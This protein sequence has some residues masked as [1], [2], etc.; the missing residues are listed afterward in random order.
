MSV[1]EQIN[2]ATLTIDVNVRAEANLDKAFLSSIKEHGVIQP[3]VAHRI[4]DGTVHVLYGQRRTLA[5]VENNLDTIPVYVVDSLTEAERLAKQIVENDQR[6]ELTDNDRAEAFHQLSLLGVSATQIARKTGARKATVDAALKVRSDDTATAFLAAG[7]T[8]DMAAVIEEFAGD[9]DAIEKLE[10][11]A[12]QA[13]QSFDHTAQRIRDD[14]KRE[15]AGAAAKAEAEA[16]GLAIIEDSAFTHYDYKG[17]IADITDLRTKTGERLTVEDA[18]AAYVRWTYSGLATAYVNTDWKAAGFVK[19]GAPRAGKMTEEEKAERRTV[20]ENNKAWDAAEVVRI[21]FV[22]G[23]LKGKTPPKNALRFIAQA[24]A[25]HS[26]TVAKGLN[27]ESDFSAEL[28]TGKTTE[29]RFGGNRELVKIASRPTARH[30][31]N[32]LAMVLAGFEKGTYRQSW[33]DGGASTKF[34]LTQLATWGYNL[35]D[36]ERLITHPAPKVAPEAAPEEAPAP[37]V[38]PEDVAEDGASG[39]D[40]EQADPEDADTADEAEAFE[41]IRT[42]EEE[43]IAEEFATAE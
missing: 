31:T 42:T 23:L 33:R 41:E 37:E 36:V 29:T 14:R 10:A 20:I 17:P 24:M 16:A 9:T 38:T 32:V 19:P 1:L 27:D 25:S 15:A 18:N 22:K 5:A 12:K 40:T 13:P 34:Y 21:E 7:M 11:A 8:L 28:L 6:R 30:E 43:M 39:A 35:S 26:N 3:V 4:E 2:P